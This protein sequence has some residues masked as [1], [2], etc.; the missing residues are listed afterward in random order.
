MWVNEAVKLS[1]VLLNMNGVQLNFFLYSAENEYKKYLYFLIVGEFILLT[2][3]T[4]KQ[5]E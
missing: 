1:L 2:Y 3:Q 4:K 5:T